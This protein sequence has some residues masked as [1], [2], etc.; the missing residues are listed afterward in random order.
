MW[1]SKPWIS[2][3]IVYF[4]PFWIKPIAIPATGA[5]I[6]TPA[7]IKLRHP[8]HIV[9]WLLLPLDSNISLTTRIV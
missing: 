5:L 4:L 6:G 3:N 8:A 9:A 7:A 2:V 1:S